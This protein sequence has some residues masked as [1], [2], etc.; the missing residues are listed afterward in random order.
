MTRPGAP[1]LDRSEGHSSSRGPMKLL[2][3]S[4]EEEDSI[5]FCLVKSL[6]WV[7]STELT[8]QEQEQDF[9]WSGYSRKDTLLSLLHANIHFTFV[10]IAASC[11]QIRSKAQCFPFVYPPFCSPPFPRKCLLE[12]SAVLKAVNIIPLKALKF[13][14]NT[15]TWTHLQPWL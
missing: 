3:A 8:P 13:L 9:S 11:V 14:L 2:Q 10:C 4:K 5:S 6:L 12:V 15:Y 1:C 7:L